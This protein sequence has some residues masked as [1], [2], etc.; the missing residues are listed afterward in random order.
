[1]CECVFFGCVRKWKVEI[2]E[3][4]QELLKLR[5]VSL[6]DNTSIPGVLRASRADLLHKYA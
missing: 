6:V 3:E 5:L 2:K 4:E 1:M